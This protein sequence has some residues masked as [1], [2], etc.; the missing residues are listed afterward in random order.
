MPKEIAHILFG[1]EIREGLDRAAKG[2]LVKHELYFHFGTMSPDL[3]YYDVRLPWETNT[4]ERFGEFI[5]SRSGNPNN[6]HILRMLEKAKALRKIDEDKA[7]RLFAFTAG[8]ISHVAVDTIFHPF[9]Y[10]VTGNYYDPDKRQRSLAE[11]G[12]RVF[13]SCLDLHLLQKNA[14][15]LRDFDL[16]RKLKLD[17]NQQQEIL[18]FYASALS[19]SYDP[20]YD[21]LGDS[22][23]AYKKRRIMEAMFQS[24]VLCEFF[25]FL[26]R[27]FGG[28]EFLLGLFYN[29]R[30]AK[31]KIDFENLE[32]VPHPV[33]GKKYT[34]RLKVL[35]T[36]AIKRGHDFLTAAFKYYSGKSPMTQTK[37]VLRPYSLNNG[38]IGVAVEKMVHYKKLSG[39]DSW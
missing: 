21:L 2:V 13:E 20:G 12:H 1:D 7:D 37:A 25:Y 10:S 3:Y 5:H 28:M 15:S 17:K 18:E 8:H 38:L 36:N 26:H 27:I 35:R 11:A 30:K 9:I 16:T 32:D 23:R 22:I 6:L 24:K 4:A 34:G 33:T 19:D 29:E 14:I 39:V 31:G